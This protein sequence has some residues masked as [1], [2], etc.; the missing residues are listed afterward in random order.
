MH[1]EMKYDALLWGLARRFCCNL[2]NPA[3]VSLSASN[4]SGFST[5]VLPA[6]PGAV[7]IALKFE[8]DL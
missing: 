2:P 8:N 6:C 4:F 3:L 5:H 1:D 7:E